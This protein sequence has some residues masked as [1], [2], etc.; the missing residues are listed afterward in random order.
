[1]IGQCSAGAD[2]EGVNFSNPLAYTQYTN[3]CI[4]ASQSPTVMIL[5]VEKGG[6]GL[7]ASPPL[8]G[9]VIAMVY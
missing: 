5:L 6:G 7:W 3:C 2:L 8:P 9:S 4:I 1:M